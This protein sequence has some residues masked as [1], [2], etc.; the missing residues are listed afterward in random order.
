[1]VV[2]YAR[3]A[4]DIT[5]QW[6]ATAA[7]YV[8]KEGSGGGGVPRGS[9]IDWAPLFAPT[10][11]CRATTALSLYE[12]LSGSLSSSPTAHRLYLPI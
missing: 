2:V 7:V 8:G 9:S 10:T 5:A 12:C 3:D 11:A 6:R 1:M 4:W